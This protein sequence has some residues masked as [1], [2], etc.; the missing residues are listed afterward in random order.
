M[1][2]ISLPAKL[3]GEGHVRSVPEL[4][5]QFE[6]ISRGFGALLLEALPLA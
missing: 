5:S 6:K 4:H 1:A 2:D 3:V